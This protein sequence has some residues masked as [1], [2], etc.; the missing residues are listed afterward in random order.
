MKKAIE[1]NKANVARKD[2]V[3]REA[4]VDQL[5]HRVLREIE[6]K[7][8]LKDL[9]VKEDLPVLK[10]V[11][12]SQDLKD[13]QVPLE[14]MDYLDTQEAGVK[15]VSKVKPVLLALL[16]LL[17]HKVQLVRMDNLENEVTPVLKEHLV[18]VVYLALLEKKVPREIEARLDFPERSDLLVPKVSLETEE[19][20]VQWVLPV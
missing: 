8:D 15:L 20:K 16:V 4:H 11:L 3:E 5:V 7:T 12:A 13:H 2:P 9:S 1:V 18:K 10:V 17:A 14:R 6:D 19:C